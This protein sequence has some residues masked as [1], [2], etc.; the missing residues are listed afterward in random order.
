MGIVD[1]HSHV[2][3]KMDDGSSGTGESLEMLKMM[4]QQGVEI[5]AATPHFYAHE[6]RPE[7]FLRRRG[8]AA[9]R[10]RSALPEGGPSV[11]LGAEIAYFEGLRNC[12]ALTPLALEGAGILL[13]EMP[14]YPWEQH[15]L[16]DI[17]QLA[18]R[19]GVVP[20]LA[21]IDR[22][23][24]HRAERGWLSDYVENGGLV[25]ANADSLLHWRTEGRVF[26]L[27]RQGLIHVLG[28]DAHNTT[29]RPPRIGLAWEK[30]VR[31]AGDEGIRYILANQE[32]FFP[33]N[34]R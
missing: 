33:D 24:L 30:I 26:R 14:F 15:M 21:H 18:D 2:L 6:D 16:G 20:M 11:L 22:Y 17:L 29:V 28:S 9:E 5:V 19:I 4:Q 31:R 7:D 25:Q 32:R 13:V 23:P 12:R 3:P 34:E 8:L 10:L 1:F 27:L